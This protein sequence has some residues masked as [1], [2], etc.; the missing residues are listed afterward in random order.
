MAGVGA[1]ILAKYKMKQL[2]RGNFPASGIWDSG[3]GRFT[4]RGIAATE[5]ASIA[6]TTCS[7]SSIWNDESRPDPGPS[8]PPLL[9]LLLNPSSTGR[10][11][12]SQ[13]SQATARWVIGHE[14]IYPESM[15]RFL[16]DVRCRP[17][18]EDSDRGVVTRRAFLDSLR[19][20]V[21]RG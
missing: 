12:R 11:E 13:P 10:R 19:R 21:E 6:F 8:N 1:A 9:L 4:I 5:T 17:P 3:Y 7:F 18:V 14:M 16:L 15:S 2:T 20:T